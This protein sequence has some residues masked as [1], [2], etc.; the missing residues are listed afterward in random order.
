MRSLRLLPV[1]AATA[2]IALPAGAQR[3]ATKAPAK[4]PAGKSAVAAP[5][6][7]RVADAPVLTVYAIDAT[8][9]ELT[10][11][12]R[13]LLGRVNGTF[14][15]WGGTVAIDTVNPANSKVDVSIKTASIDTKNGQRDNHLRSP[16]FFAADSFPAIT[17][18]SRSVVK[19]GNKLRIVGDL[20]MRGVTR[21]VVLLG[22][23]NGT[24]KDPWGK[25]R[26]A[27]TAST[28]VNRNDFG[29]A[30]NKAVETGTMLGDE[31]SID[32]ALEAVQQ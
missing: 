11:R 10:F 2:L 1:L 19:Q 25:T 17:F 26:T 13:H 28:T 30:Y 29:V 6:T 27:F 4:T 20:T 21:P 15:E 5:A 23:Y 16:D 18:K 14:G 8:H 22:D 9:S 7:A 31:V 3:A 32:I 24:F 12:I